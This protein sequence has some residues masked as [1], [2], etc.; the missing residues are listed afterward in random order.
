MTEIFYGEVSLDWNLTG[1]VY[2]L[3]EL[4]VEVQPDS[5]Q[6]EVDVV[7]SVRETDR[8]RWFLGAPVRGGLSRGAWFSV[9]SRLPDW[10]PSYLQLPT[11]FV[12]LNLTGPFF[13]LPLSHSTRHAFQSPW[14][15][16]IFPARAGDQGFRFPLRPR[17]PRCCWLRACIKPSHAWPNGFNPRLACQFRFNGTRQLQTNLASLLPGF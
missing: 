11:H 4:D 9:G 5:A 8:G 12:A 17:G 16:P 15:V 10:G 14:H 13:G 2:P 3:S 1:L 7:I 6:H